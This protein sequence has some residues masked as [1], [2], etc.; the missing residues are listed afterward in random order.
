MT[1]LRTRLKRHMMPV[2]ALVTF[3][4]SAA[5]FWREHPVHVGCVTVLLVLYW[6]VEWRGIEGSFEDRVPRHWFITVSRA[7][8]LPGL[9]LCVLDCFWLR[10]TPRAFPWIELA[11][12][13][14]YIAGLGLRLWSMHALRSAFS[15]DLKVGSG[16][17]LVTTGPYRL[18]RHPSY[19]GLV[20]WSAGLG[21]LVPS[22]PGV[23]VLVA[24]TVPQI[25][26]RIR[27]EERILE[28]HFGERWRRYASGTRALV[29][30][31]W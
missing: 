19:A 17:E 7:L 27:I 23:I 5:A 25:V 2:V 16:Q 12:T 3:E 21:L 22:L 26:H 11:G 24:T 10:W 9:V 4:A 30:L 31:V 15:Y 6:I 29:P 1:S 8:W 18:L 13:V 14:L 20:L 28:E